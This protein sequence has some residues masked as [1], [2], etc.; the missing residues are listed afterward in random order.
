MMI[1]GYSSLVCQAGTV[2]WKKVMAA[3]IPTKGSRSLKAKEEKFKKI[4]KFN[5][6]NHKK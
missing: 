6:T 4:A 1:Y 5:K 3:D 2:Q